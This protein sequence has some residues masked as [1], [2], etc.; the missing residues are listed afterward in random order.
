[1]K[2]LLTPLICAALLLPSVGRAGGGRYAFT[3][4]TPRE[5]AEVVRALEASSFDWGL[6]SD[7]VIVHIARGVVSR[8]IPGEGWLDADLLD[9]DTFAWGVVQHEF[10]HQVDFLLL[11]DRD[12]DGLLRLVGESVWCAPAL[13]SADQGC[14]RF[15]SAV[16]WAYWPSRDNCMRPDAETRRVTARFRSRLE[17]LL[18]IEEGVLR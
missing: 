16:A 4:G 5:R 2:L 13:P 6:V 17:Q 8:S 14:E 3:G 18:P 12:R 9:A 7:R 10:A 11:T 15:A 1:M